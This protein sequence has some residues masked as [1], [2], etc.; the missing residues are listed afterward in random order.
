MSPSGSRERSGPQ[1]GAGDL[2]PLAVLTG[3]TGTGK[4][5]LAL[6]LADEFPIELVSVDSAQVYRGMDL[7]SAKPDAATRARVPHHLL[8]LVEPNQSYSAGQF[9]RDCTRCIEDI[10]SRGKI[11]LLVGGTMLYLRALI[12]GIAQLP[13]GS[14]EIRA[15]LDAEAA[16]VG[17][18]ALHG[19]LAQV[20]PDAAARIHPNDAQR[21]Q[22]ALEVYEAGGRAISE[23][24]R[25]TRSVLA[26]DFVIAALMPADR[27]RLH[28]DLAR[29]FE[30]MMAAGFLDEVRRLRGRGDLSDSLPAIRAVGYRQ[31][32]AHLAGAYPIETAIDRAIAATRQLAKRQMTWLRSMPNIEL[33]DPHDAQSL[34]GIRETLKGAFLPRSGALTL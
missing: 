24:Q 3:P 6:R 12:G 17:W 8:D 27:A 11:P 30:K 25:S 28:E 20:D 4:S 10:E 14:E 15:R 1:P 26:R 34:V 19:R 13:E 9:V 32:W 23:L 16:R 22:R 29:R 31:L 21:I 33:F 2:R 7:G 5:D 18:G